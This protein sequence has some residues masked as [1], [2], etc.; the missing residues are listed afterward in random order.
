M[1]RNRTCHGFSVDHRNLKKTVIELIRMYAGFICVRVSIT[2]RR[3]C[4]SVPGV[5][6]LL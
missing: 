5:L 6:F 1:C 4:E 3:G 2:I